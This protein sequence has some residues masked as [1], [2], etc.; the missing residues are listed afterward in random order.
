MNLA[1]EMP[2]GIFATPSDD[3]SRCRYVVIMPLEE[4]LEMLGRVAWIHSPAR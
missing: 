2:S 3:S 4:L 1:E